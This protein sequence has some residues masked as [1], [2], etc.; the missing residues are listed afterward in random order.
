VQRPLPL[1]ARLAARLPRDWEVV[2]GPV[3]LVVSAVLAI[4]V[5]WLLSSAWASP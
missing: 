5:A 4:V 3:A 1:P 2:L